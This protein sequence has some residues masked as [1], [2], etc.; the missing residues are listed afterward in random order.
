MPI[1]W[2][3]WESLGR[4]RETEVS[5]PFVQSNQDG[6]L[7]V[8]AIGQGEIFNLPQLAPNGRWSDS[9]RSK[10]APSSKVHLKRHVVG[11][12]ADGR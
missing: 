7:E 4:P 2:G 1:N 9:W 12:N 8:F 11:W 3:P 10:G 5:R 6:R